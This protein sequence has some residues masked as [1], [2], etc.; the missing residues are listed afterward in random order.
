MTTVD[1]DC[2]TLMIRSQAGDIAAFAALC[3]MFAPVI[4]S[5]LDA[6][7]AGLGDDARLVDEVFAAIHSA[8]RTYDPRK[9]FEPW[10]IAVARHVALSRRRK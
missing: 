1:D 10:A 6:F 8:R 2:R 3:E 4:C 5:Y 7:A 9:P